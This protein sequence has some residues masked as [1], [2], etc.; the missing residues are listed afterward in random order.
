MLQSCAWTPVSYIPGHAG[1]SKNDLHNC[2]AECGR[3]LSLRLDTWTL[4]QAG[5]AVLYQSP[6]DS[7]LVAPYPF[8][9]TKTPT[10]TDVDSGHLPAG[11][12]LC[13]TSRNSHQ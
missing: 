6:L 7:P 10:D 1:V 2:D 12:G 3:L 9:Q 8:G 4:R 5:V 11:A 13:S